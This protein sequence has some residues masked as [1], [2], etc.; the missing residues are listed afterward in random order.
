[1]IR[2]WKNS[3]I[4]NAPY[5]REDEYGAKGS[6]VGATPEPCKANHKLIFTTMKDPACS[7]PVRFVD[8]KHARYGREGR[9]HG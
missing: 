3:F 2:M 5:S 8:P 1:M 9:T 4:K 6:V 7:V